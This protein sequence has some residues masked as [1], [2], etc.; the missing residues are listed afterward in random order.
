LEADG[1]WIVEGKDLQRRQQQQHV[2]SNRAA[3]SSVVVLLG[4]FEFVSAG[5]GYVW[6]HVMRRQATPMMAE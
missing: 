6:R 1:A 4:S 2:V 5:R 3:T